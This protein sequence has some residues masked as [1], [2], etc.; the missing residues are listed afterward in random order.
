MSINAD[1]IAKRVN[2]VVSP[3]GWDKFNRNLVPEM[4]FAMQPR[5]APTI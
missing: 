1:R 2:L 3:E 4:G 5:A